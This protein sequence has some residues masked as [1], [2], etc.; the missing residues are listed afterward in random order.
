MTLTM[1]HVNKEFMDGGFEIIVGWIKEDL[2]AGH[3]SID[4]IHDFINMY[5]FGTTNRHITEDEFY[6]AYKSAEIV[7]QDAIEFHRRKKSN[8]MFRRQ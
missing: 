7:C 1:T 5:T 3:K 4:E 2:L 6:I 8:Q